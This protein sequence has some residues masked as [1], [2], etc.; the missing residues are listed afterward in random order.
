VLISATR[1]QQRWVRQDKLGPFMFAI[2]IKR[3]A[4]LHSV[5][6]C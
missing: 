3:N 5:F 6:S 4:N 2:N 1:V